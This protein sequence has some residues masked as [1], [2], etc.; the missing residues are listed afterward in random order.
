MTS[1][2][3]RMSSAECRDADGPESFARNGGAGVSPV[4]HQ[5]RQ[6]ARRPPHHQHPIVKDS[7]IGLM[8][9]ATDSERTPRGL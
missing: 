2:K 7:L 4:V 3:C 5:G 8:I 6:Q 9:Q 1:D